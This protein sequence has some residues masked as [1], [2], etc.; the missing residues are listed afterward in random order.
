MVS[1][2]GVVLDGDF[3]PDVQGT[4]SVPPLK[5]PEGRYYVLGDNR[6]NSYDSHAWDSSGPPERREELATV[7]VDLVLGELPADTRKC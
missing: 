6:R 4:Y 5:I 1:I 7:P 3:Y 2:D